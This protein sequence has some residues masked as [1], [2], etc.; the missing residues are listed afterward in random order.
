MLSEV[1]LEGDDLDKVVDIIDAND[2]A[3]LGM[4]AA[5][6]FGIVDTE[7]RSPIAAA[8]FSGLLFLTGALPSVIPFAFLSDTGT[9]LLVAGIFTGIGLV[10]VG[11]AK[12]KQTGKN[13]VLSALENLALGLAGG[14][15]AYLVGTAF[16]SMI[17]R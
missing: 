10:L 17:T 2:D 9:A 13:P 6:E 14:L 15:L 1:G 5:L 3:M 11:A 7:R 16:D 8:I 12:T 4:H